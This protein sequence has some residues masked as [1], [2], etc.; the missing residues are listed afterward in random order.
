M[1]NY[2]G[3]LAF[4]A[5]NAVA[6][7]LGRRLGLGVG[8]LLIG[9]TLL[10]QPLSDQAEIS[11]LTY[12]PSDELYA[13]FG[14]SALRVRDPSSS[15][16]V[17]YNYGM[18]SFTEGN[19]YFKFAQGKLNYWLGAYE[20]QYLAAEAQQRNC[21]IREQVL[22]LTSTEQQAVYK[23]LT[24]NLLPKNRYYR[25]DFFYDNCVTRVRDLMQ[26]VLG[27]RLRLDT[28][29][30]QDY[31]FRDL[32]DLY[33]EPQ[34]WG[35]L[36]ID[37]A[38]GARID[39]RAPAVDYLFLP[40]YAAQSFANSRVV[41]DGEAVPLVKEEIVLFEEHPD[42][43]VASVGFWQPEWIFSAILGVVLLVTFLTRHRPPVYWPDALLFALYGLLGLVL[44]LLWFA[45]N[46]QATHNNYN[47]LWLHPLHLLSAALLLRKKKG[48][49]TKLYL[50]LNGLG[51]LL[52]LAMWDVI[53]QAYHPA[54]IPLVVLLA[55]RY[56]YT[57]STIEL[58]NKQLTH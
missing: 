45:T 30:V 14:H 9:T 53:P 27:D 52:L 42:Q 43:E 51:G 36:G 21:T 58:R 12:S 39:Q 46:H 2:Q 50:L 38:L 18:F 13:A 5:F 57:Y 47:L 44:L 48:L 54:F 1:V 10:A 55:F 3:F 56:F 49:G 19:F 37:L 15:L 7:R 32:I 20:F 31:S 22:N 25:Y 33:M 34:A 17:V 24:T 35:D 4:G 41:C 6:K 29:F 40:A 26:Q 11:L 28:S 16:D 23:Y 8:L